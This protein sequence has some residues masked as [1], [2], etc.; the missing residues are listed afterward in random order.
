MDVVLNPKQVIRKCLYTQSRY[1]GKGVLSSEGK[2]T[3][4]KPAVPGA[5]VK[6]GLRPDMSWLLPEP[7]ILSYSFPLLFKRG[8]AQNIQDNLKH[9]G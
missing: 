9:F 6:T 5:E 1:P 4:A 3:D 7:Q 8:R 2:C